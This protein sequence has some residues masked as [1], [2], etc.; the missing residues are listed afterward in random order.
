MYATTLY[1]LLFCI[2]IEYLDAVFCH[3]DNSGFCNLANALSGS[4]GVI[5]FS[6]SV[7]VFTLN[8]SKEGVLT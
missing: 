1:S 5:P 8:V 6:G 3:I 2:F 4:G 7:G